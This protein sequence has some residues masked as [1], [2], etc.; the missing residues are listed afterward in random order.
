MIHRKTMTSISFIVLLAVLLCCPHCTLSDRIRSNAIA[1]SAPSDDEG[2]GSNAVAAKNSVLK[3]QILEE[4][5][6]KLDVE[7]RKRERLARAS[8]GGLGTRIGGTTASSPSSA[9][10]ESSSPPS[11]SISSSSTAAA[12]PAATEPQYDPYTNNFLILLRTK[13]GESCIHMYIHASYHILILLYDSF[14]IFNLYRPFSLE[15]RRE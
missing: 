12:A 4:D 6:E 7:R 15:I 14:F 11:D 9:A 8:G 10:E 1:S 5:E 3:G 13:D 2:G